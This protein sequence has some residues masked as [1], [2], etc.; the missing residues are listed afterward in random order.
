MIYFNGCLRMLDDL[1]EIM[2]QATE[3]MKKELGE[4]FYLQYRKGALSGTKN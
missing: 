2:T 1:Q 4:E 3:D